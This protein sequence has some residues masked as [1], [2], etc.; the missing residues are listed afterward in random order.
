MALTK[1]TTPELLDFPDD[2]TSSANTSGTVIPTG[3]TAAQPSVSLNAGEFRFNTT[4]SYV[5]YYNGTIW[6]QIDDA[7]V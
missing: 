3:N 7:A 2:S 1:I 6:K 4:L 5:E